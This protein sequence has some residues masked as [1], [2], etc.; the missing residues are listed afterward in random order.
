MLYVL[1]G[2]LRRVISAQKVEAEI[3]ADN[4]AAVGNRPDLP[5]GEVAA[6]GRERKAV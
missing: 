4:A 2:A 3:Y 5:V 1:E 6:Y